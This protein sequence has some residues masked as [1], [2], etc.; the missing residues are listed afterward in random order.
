MD[1]FKKLDKLFSEFIRRREANSDGFTKCFTCGKIGHWKEFHNGHYWKRQYLGTY[2]DEQ[3]CNVQCPRC[4]LAY[5]YGLDGN[6]QEY[7]QALVRK[8][9]QSILTI[10]EL[11][12]KTITKYPEWRIKLMIFEYKEKIKNL[13][14]SSVSGT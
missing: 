4:N 2:F 10:L 9:G 12:A 11:R 3:N 13:V 1:Y 5:P 8:Y 6:Y 14:S 7:T